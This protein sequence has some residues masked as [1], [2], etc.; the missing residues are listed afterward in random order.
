[1]CSVDA[2]LLK[3]RRNHDFRLRGKLP[4]GVTRELG[5][6]IE[7]LIQQHAGQKTNKQTRQDITRRLKITSFVLI[8]SISVL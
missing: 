1:V 3:V 2:V 4:E 7:N 8:C 6:I 5:R